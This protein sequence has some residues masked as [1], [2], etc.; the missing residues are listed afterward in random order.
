[1][2]KI[3]KTLNKLFPEVLSNEDG[4]VM[5][6]NPITIVVF[7]LICLAVIIKHIFF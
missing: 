3:I 6:D 4:V 5:D 2:D 1:M 7:G